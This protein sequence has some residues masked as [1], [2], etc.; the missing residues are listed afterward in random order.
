MVWHLLKHSGRCKATLH[1]AKVSN[2]ELGLLCSRFARVS[3]LE[4]GL[5]CLRLAQVFLRESDFRYSCWGRNLRRESDS[6]KY[7]KGFT[8]ILRNLFSKQ[9]RQSF[10]ATA[11]R[12]PSEAQTASFGLETRC[13]CRWFFTVGK[14]KKSQGAS[15]RLYGR[16]ARCEE[17]FA[18]TPV[19]KSRRSFEKTT[20]W[21]Q[22]LTFIGPWRW[23]RKIVRKSHYFSHF[24]VSHESRSK[25]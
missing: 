14:K 18:W 22:Y 1:F 9:P 12:C 3:D 17:S 15:T 13:P 8:N 23:I 24:S 20:W 11:P 2:G 19:F 25:E 4:L 7:R 6:L 16:C 5:L 10:S 21:K